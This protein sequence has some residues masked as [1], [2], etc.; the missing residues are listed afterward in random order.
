MKTQSVITLAIAALLAASPYVSF[1]Q[2]SNGDDSSVPQGTKKVMLKI[3]TVETA[4]T[5]HQKTW[6]PPAK[7]LEMTEKPYSEAQIMQA[8]PEEAARMR[9]KNEAAGDAQRIANAKIAIEN[10]NAA[11]KHMKGI[12]Y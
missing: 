10:W 7:P 3:S 8:T 9:A 2:S 1:A 11:D 4:G 5:R 6:A 12:H